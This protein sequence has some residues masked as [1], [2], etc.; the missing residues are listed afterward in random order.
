MVEEEE[1]KRYAR[2]VRILRDLPTDSATGSL[3][4]S[5]SRNDDPIIDLSDYTDSDIESQVRLSIEIYFITIYDIGIEFE[6]WLTA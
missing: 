5:T 2:M 4:S 1:D 6:P 3:G